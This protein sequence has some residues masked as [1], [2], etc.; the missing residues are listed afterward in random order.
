VALRVLHQRGRVIE[1]E[2]II[3]EHRAEKR[4]RVMHLEEGRGVCDQREARR[5]RLGE[6]IQGERRDRA[7]DRVRG[8]VFDAVSR[9]AL[10]E[11][12]LDRAHALDR[13]LEAHR[14]P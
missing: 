5:V 6:T 7:D 12:C 4:R 10:V 9:H 1:A 3:V 8:L 14:T 13:S 11:P 2:R